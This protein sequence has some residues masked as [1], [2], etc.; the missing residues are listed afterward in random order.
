MIIRL[1]KSGEY[2]VGADSTTGLQ[3]VV[4][5]PVKD[6]FSASQIDIT[7][8]FDGF[9]KRIHSHK[10]SEIFGS[11]VDSAIEFK[12][13]VTVDKQIISSLA[14]GTAPLAIT[15]KTLVTNLNAEMVGGKKLVD[16]AEKATTL[17][18]YGI[19]DAYTKDE[20][21]TAIADASGGGTGT[22]PYPDAPPTSPSIYDDEFDSATLNA[23]WSIKTALTAP[24]TY[25]INT[26]VPS[27]LMGKFS[28]ATGPTLEIVQAFAVGNIISAGVA[29]SCTAKVSNAGQANFGGVVISTQDSLA[30]TNRVF[31][32][33]Q[34]AT[35][36][37]NNYGKRVAGVDT[38][39]IG[40][41]TTSLAK[42][43]LHMQRDT[44]NIW[45]FFYSDDGISWFKLGTTD[46]TLAFAISHILL[47]V[48][49]PGSS[50][51]YLRC[52]IDWLRV[53]W[54]TL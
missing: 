49:G 53:N 12:E 43:Y 23:K 7:K 4:N 54:L 11:S 46:V 33:A 13:D 36:H 44:S 35:G 24:N 45:R 3:D 16:L 31:I 1:I 20:V 34:Y 17:A 37:T 10:V 14:D 32:A 42:M 25:D 41:V 2:A 26:S 22:L 47:T 39:N 18:G 6:I 28:N 51:S 27:W 5:R 9:A 38:F 52:G 21:D 15:S 8:D 50:N 40:Q 19:E 48:T 29:Y 30:G